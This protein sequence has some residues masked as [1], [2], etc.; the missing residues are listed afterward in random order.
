MNW[1]AAGVII[2]IIGQ[3]VTLAIAIFGRPKNTSEIC[4]MV[5]QVKIALQ[6][7]VQGQDNLRR[8]VEGIEREIK[9]M[10]KRLDEHTDKLAKVNERIAVLR[11]MRRVQDEDEDEE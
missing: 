3:A 4:D 7:L 9:T 1:A 2:L 5:N 6:S 11:A 10:W 8:S